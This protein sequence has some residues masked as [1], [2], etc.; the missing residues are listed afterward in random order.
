MLI[1]DW[2]LACFCVEPRGLRPGCL[3]SGGAGCL[4]TSESAAQACTLR[5]GTTPGTWDYQPPSWSRGGILTLW[6]TPGRVAP[7]QRRMKLG[8]DGMCSAGASM[9]MHRSLFSSSSGVT[10][11]TGRPC[12]RWS[13]GTSQKTRRC[14]GRWSAVL[15][16]GEEV[17]LLRIT[18]A[19]GSG[20]TALHE[21]GSNSFALRTDDQISLS[22]AEPNR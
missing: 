6:C 7:R 22:L 19:H 1:S 14:C 21:H 16:R 17:G 9:A 5:P 10:A 2:L 18:R 20:P 11:H 15:S 4:P 8:L 13:R 3:C 12:V